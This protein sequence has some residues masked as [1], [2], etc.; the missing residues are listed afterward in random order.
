MWELEFSTYKAAK[1]VRTINPYYSNSKSYIY[2]KLNY[3]YFLRGGMGFQNI[4]NRKPYWGGIQLSVIYYAGA[5]LGITKPYYLLVLNKDNQIIENRF[6][7]DSTGADN[8][9]GRGSFL[10]GVLNIGLHP[11]A[12]AKGGLEFEFGTRN[13]TIKALELGAI[14]DYSPLPIAI[15]AFNSKQSLFLTVY[16]SFSMGKRYNKE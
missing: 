4:L 5:L 9:I 12:Y 2:G 10:T 14:L 11:G 3:V 1:E 16:L 13:R 6:D 8:I 15:M 7:P